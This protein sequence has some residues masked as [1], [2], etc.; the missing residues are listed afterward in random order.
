MRQYVSCLKLW[1][2]L[3]F[4]ITH[5]VSHRLAYRKL[6][7]VE[8]VNEIIGYIGRLL[9]GN[10]YYNLSICIVALVSVIARLGFPLGLSIIQVL[11]KSH[12]MD[13][14]KDIR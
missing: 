13:L 2:C 7:L 12:G 14:V 4:I 8:P 11:C 3:M 9:L 1:L 5:A 10:V 6:F